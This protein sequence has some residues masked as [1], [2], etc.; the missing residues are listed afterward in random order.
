VALAGHDLI[1]VVGAPV[2]RYH[3]YE[4]GAC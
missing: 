4:P 2:F 3:Q 1:L